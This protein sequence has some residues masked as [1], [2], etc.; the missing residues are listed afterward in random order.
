MKFSK[1]LL[2]A[3]QKFKR[4]FSVLGHCGNKPTADLSVA[5]HHMSCKLQRL[6]PYQETAVE[7]ALSKPF[8]LIQG[9]PG[10][11]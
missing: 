7:Q 6:D 4:I 2:V 5:S 1:R 3:T 10:K 11:M 8:T 9:P